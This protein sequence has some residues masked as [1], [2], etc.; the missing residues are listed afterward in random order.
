MWNIL[1]SMQILTSFPGFEIF[2]SEKRDGDFRKKEIFPE[3]KRS[4]KQIH[5]TAICTIT[6]EN[7]DVSFEWY[8]GVYTGE[9]WITIGT[10]C[11]D[12]PVII[13]MGE[14]ECAAVHSGWR[15]T[16]AHIVQCAIG[17]FS[18]PHERIRGYIWPHISGDS[19]EVQEDFLEHFDEKY[20]T[21]KEGKIYC[22]L[23]SVILD[24]M[25]KSWILSSNITVSDRDTFRD[26]EY[27]SYRRDRN[28]GIGL[29]GVKMI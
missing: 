13:L 1:S 21:K 11:A 6:R 19:Y 2:I 18:T 12:C 15:G 10:M 28:T 4:S 25:I 3:I 8:D 9:K 14:G 24:D 16:K 7:A 22:D 29:V 27:Q 26:L 23:A 17:G 5:G 20:F